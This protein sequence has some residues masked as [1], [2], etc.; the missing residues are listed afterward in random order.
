MM[1]RTGYYEDSALS[2]SGADRKDH[3]T[4]V[5]GVTMQH[6][7]F[8][9]IADILKRRFSHGPIGSHYG[10]TTVATDGTRLWSALDICEVFALELGATNPRFNSERF[11]RACG[12]EP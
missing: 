2:K 3:A 9:A 11:L 8:A 7:H 1:R 6:R 5:Y 4:A 12:F 10:A